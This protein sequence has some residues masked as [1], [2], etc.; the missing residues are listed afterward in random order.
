MTA[1]LPAGWSS[2]PATLDDTAAILA[3]IH[4]AD[5]V[6]IGA[7]DTSSEHVVE[8]LSAAHTESVVA[9]DPDGRIAGWASVWNP[10]RSEFEEIDLYTHPESGDPTRSPLLDWCLATVRR[11]ARDW[12]RPALTV[13][14][15]VVPTETGLVAAL[16]AAGFSFHKRYARMRV[17]L[18]HPVPVPPPD[19]VTIRL[20]DP[21]DE[22][23][24]RTFHRI[25]TTAFADSVDAVAEPFDEWRAG[26][27][28]LP[29][30]AWD[31][32]WVASVAG[33]PAGVL[34]SANQ[35]LEQGGGWVKNL[36]VLREYRGRGIGRA[37]L[38]RAFATYHAKG[39]AT[40]GLGVD[41]TNPTGAYGVYRSVGMEPVFEADMYQLVVSV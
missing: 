37:L 36:A 14:T 1:A 13:R 9:V 15:G 34:Q 31:E 20:L 41:L 40:A 22:A 35:A 8:T 28:R 2:R 39:R 26:I 32:W 6:A 4:A 3:V 24:L 38:S 11:R 10:T 19:G 21:A 5:T 18:P 30:V 12:G 17:D 33:V 29:S 7:P 23:D 25:L 27:E 16:V